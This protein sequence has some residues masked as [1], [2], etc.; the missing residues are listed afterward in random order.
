MADVIVKI[1]TIDALVKNMQDNGTMSTLLIGTGQATAGQIKKQWLGSK[2][3]DN[4]PFK[5]GNK[6]YLASKAA[7]GRNGVIDM[8]Y[9]G[10][11]AKSFK[12]QSATADSATIGFG[13]DQLEKA[14]GNYAR[15]PNMLA[16]D[17]PGIQAFATNAF[18]KL[19][20]KVMKL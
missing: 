7:S 18:Y 12:V 20:K 5:K 4:S 19:F 15:R 14:R 16:V 1:P 8:Y 3:A 9:T 13:G 11:M 6:D 10:K 2:G 17:D